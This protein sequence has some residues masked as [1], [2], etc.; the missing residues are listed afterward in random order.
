MLYSG[1]DRDENRYH[2]IGYAH[3]ED[4][5]IWQR[6]SHPVLVPK[7]VEEY[8]TCPALLRNADGTVRKEGGCYRMWLSGRP[9]S[10]HILHARS[11][12]GLE[13]HLE[14]DNHLN[15]DAYSP[16]VIFEDGIYKMWFTS[17]GKR[18]E[19]SIAYSESGDGISWEAVARSTVRSTE[20]W[21]QKNLLYPFVIMRDGK[22]E[23]YYTSYGRTC[24]IGLAT[25]KD[26]LQWR[27]EEGPIISPDPDSSWDSLYCS[28][29]CIV[30]ETEGRDKLY[31]ASRID[32][33]HK[34]YAIGL[35]VDM[36]G[37]GR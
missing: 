36:A 25:S 34:Y 24:E 5:L 18:G 7:S 29:A 28:K 35:A 32:M 12:D 6:L 17:I 11:K 30:P 3:S 21:E 1:S 19:M 10:P 9:D 8:Y 2:R 13:W 37:N 20:E 33:H 16:N 23:M 15:I 27:K 31:Y 4:G 22:F 26:G 14:P